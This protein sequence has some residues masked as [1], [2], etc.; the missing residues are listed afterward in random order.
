MR[1]NTNEVG[2]RTGLQSPWFR[3]NLYLDKMGIVLVVILTFII[4]A[5]LDSQFLTW[6]NLLNMIR[7]T[8][9][10]GILAAGMT[11]VIL[12]GGIDLSVGAIVALSGV[13]GVYFSLHMPTPLAVLLGVCVGALAGFV[14]GFLTA[15]TRLPS[16]IVTLG[17]MT[18]LRGIAYVVTGG[19]PLVLV[20]ESFKKIGMGYLGPVPIPII[21]MLLVYAVFFVILRYTVFGR[22]VYMIGGNKEAAYLT[23]IKV[24]PRLVWVYTISGICSAIAGII[25][26]ARLFSGQP[27]VGMGYELDAIA[28]VVLGGTSL[29]GGMG[30]IIGSLFGAI[31]MGALSNG[32]TLMSV[33]Y[34]WQLIIKGLVIILAIYIDHLRQRNTRA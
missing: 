11:F 18:Y 25:L 13:C 31:F 14:N 32:L 33:P 9:I 6:S 24:V 12:T 28:A 29:A 27:N 21:I 2:V 17:S 34:Y 20:S 19:Y 10:N 7:Q 4:F 3:I 26:A 23:G 22:N 8:A 16:I 1:G 15:K 30:T 5:V